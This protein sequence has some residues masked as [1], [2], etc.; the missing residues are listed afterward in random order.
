VDQLS[1]RVAV[2]TGGAGGIGRALAEELL[3]E[4]MKVVVADVQ[5]GPLEA[6]VGELSKTGEALGV[7]TD[8]TDRKSVDALADR[9][10]EAFGA[11]HVLC[12]N[13][14][15]GA[16]SSLVWETTANDWKWVHGVNVMG[17]VHGI[18]SFVPRMIAGGE[19]GHV[20]NTS[21][22]D[23]G[24]SPMP[25]ASVYA[26][27]KAAVTI[28]TECLA[29]QLVSEGTNLRASIF[30][31]SGGLLKTGLWESEKTRPPELAREVPRKTE[32]MTVA[33]LE[34]M[35]AKSGQQL[36]WQDLNELAS[37]VVRGIK[38]EKFILMLDLEGIGPQLRKRAEHFEKGELVPHA[39]GMLG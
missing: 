20:V 5:P 35:A 26:S 28:L 39:K 18:L 24:I 25:A 37:V 13:A 23:G 22:G 34:A 27:S 2:V 29:S 12:N 6:T 8:V 4:G 38:E 36:P 19:P 7:A 1:G 3:Q 31:P 15:V 21:S 33:K 16:P 30:Y 14:G 11:C 9:T 32:A 17:V 10:Y